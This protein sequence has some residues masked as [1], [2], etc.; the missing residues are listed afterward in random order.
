MRGLFDLLI[1]LFDL[2]SIFVQRN[3]T[4]RRSLRRVL[5]WLLRLRYNDEL[6]A[7]SELWGTQDQ[8]CPLTHLFEQPRM[9]RRELVHALHR[10]PSSRRQHTSS[11]PRVEDVPNLI[12][13]LAQLRRVRGVERVLGRRLDDDARVEAA[14][15]EDDRAPDV[16]V[17]VQDRLCARQPSALSCIH[18][19][20]AGA[21]RADRG[22]S[23]RRC[24]A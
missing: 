17:L 9:R 21:H 11:T 3:V 2:L 24:C 22:S 16:R 15:A 10:R 14:A 6:R 18:S 19:A 8:T 4:A 13:E 20:N 23:S 5:E 7:K 12:A 1:Q